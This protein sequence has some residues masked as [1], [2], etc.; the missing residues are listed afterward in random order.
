MKMRW[1]LSSS[2]SKPRS[3][4]VRSTPTEIKQRENAPASN[5]VRLV[6]L[7]QI[8]PIMIVTRDKKREGRRKKRRTT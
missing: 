4:D 7:L 2:A 5:A 6:T 8:I 1:R 3:K